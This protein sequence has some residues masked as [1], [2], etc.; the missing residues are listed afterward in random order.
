[1]PDRYYSSLEENVLPSHK[2]EYV[3]LQ[4]W[5]DEPE[6]DG[7]KE[8]PLEELLT[9][10]WMIFCRSMAEADELW[11]VLK[12][13]LYTHELGC[14]MKSATEPS[15]NGVLICIYTDDWCDIADIKRV[16][17]TLR[18]LGRQEKLYYK[19]DAQT[20]LGISGSIYV[21]PENTLI[22]VTKKGHEWFEFMKRPIP[23]M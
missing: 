21:S 3:W 4:C 6:D 16:L 13:A 17:Q 11:P 19:A 22:E 10:K 23:E 14:S 18:N 12:K 9:G 7:V 15:R 20:M 1:M 8:E 2:S 5:V